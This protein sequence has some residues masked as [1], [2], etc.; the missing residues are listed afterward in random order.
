MRIPLT[1]GQA[2][3]IHGWLAPK[4][5]LSWN[6]VLNSDNLTFRSLHF[7]TNITKDLLYKMQPD[8]S[9]WV[10]H[11]RVCLGDIAHL[12]HWSA[13]PIR[14]L[15]AD[16]GNLLDMHWSAAEMHQRGV[17][18]ADLVEAGLT[19]ETMALFGYTLYEWSTLGFRQADAEALTEA[20]LSRLFRMTRV[21]VIRCC[22]K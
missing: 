21:D 13:H 9:A 18:Y 20:S 16:L 15:K 8:I 2:V 14:D 10:K 5:T 7:D 6:D 4:K 22:V 11:G 17:T 3:T 1:A 12:A 19:H